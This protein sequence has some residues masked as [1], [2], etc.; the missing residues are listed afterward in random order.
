MKCHTATEP[1]GDTCYCQYG[2]ARGHAFW[3]GECADYEPVTEPDDDFN[4][5]WE[6]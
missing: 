6:D 1:Q 2:S 4:E 5:P 3:P